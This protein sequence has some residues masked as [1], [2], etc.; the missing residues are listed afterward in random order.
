[1][2]KLLPILLLVTGCVMLFS[3]TQASK[4]EFR[5]RS[6]GQ[7]TSD[8]IVNAQ[9]KILT[10][11]QILFKAKKAADPKAVAEAQSS[12]AAAQT[13]ATALVKQAAPA[14]TATAT[15][16][17]QEHDQLLQSVSDFYNDKV[18]P[19]SNSASNLESGLTWMSLAL[20]FF[21]SV[22]SAFNWNKA[23]GLLAASVVLA[24]GAPNVLPIHQKAVYYQALS[25]QTN[26]LIASLNITAQLTSASYDDDVRKWQILQNA[27]NY[28]GGDSAASDLLTSLEAS[29]IAVQ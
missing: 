13:A 20:G 18:V 2:K 11:Q 28:P 21:S 1:M 5:I 22:C 25:N 3:Q 9:R 27:I 29:K 14:A 26:S 16:S 8:Q 23:A 24:S 4:P 7:D 15:V 6:L 10:Q 17:S 12:L 19:E